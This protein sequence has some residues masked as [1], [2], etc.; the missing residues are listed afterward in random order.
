MELAA[1][2]ADNNLAAQM[3][4]LMAPY[5]YLRS[6]GELTAIQRSM[7]SDVYGFSLE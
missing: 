4:Q 1:V 2:L 6:Y 7:Y 3:G 5:F